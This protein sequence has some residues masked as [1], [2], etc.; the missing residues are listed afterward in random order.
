MKL[1]FSF[2]LFTETEYK[3]E[4]SAHLF[5]LFALLVACSPSN[6]DQYAIG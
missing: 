3:D 4:Y 6:I 1:I 2:V 5:P